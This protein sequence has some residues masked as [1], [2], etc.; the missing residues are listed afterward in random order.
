VV[1]IVIP[2]SD[3]PW[4]IGEYANHAG[5]LPP[6]IAATAALLVGS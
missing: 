2:I 5:M 1:F 6:R 4:M 3:A